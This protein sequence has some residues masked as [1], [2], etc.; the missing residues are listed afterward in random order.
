LYEAIK[1]SVKE[2][3]LKFLSSILDLSRNNNH[4]HKQTAFISLRIAE[5]MGLSPE[6]RD[7]LFIASLIHDSG[8]LWGEEEELAAILE[9]SNPTP[10]RHCLLAYLLLKNS[11][12]ITRLIPDV[13]RII[14][15]HHTKF[16]ELTKPEKCRLLLPIIEFT[17]EEVP[18]ESLIINI[19]SAISMMIDDQ[20][21]IL[22][23]AEEIKDRIKEL[24]DSLF[25]SDIVDAL[26]EAS[27]K[28]AFWLTLTSPFLE[29]EVEAIYPL[30]E[31]IMSKEEMVSLF[32]LICRFVDYK[33][34]LFATHSAGVSAMAE[35]LAELAQLSPDAVEK[36]KIAGYIHDL[37]KLSLPLSIVVKKDKLTKEEF[38]LVKVHPFTIYSLL[39][40]TK[41]LEG[42]RE[43]VGFHHERLDGSGYPFGLKG[44]AL[45][46]EARLL[47]VVDVFSALREKRPY[48]P[49]LEFDDA[50]K[51]LEEEAKEGKLD[52]EIVALLIKN[53]SDID[54]IF[55]NTH[56]F[57]NER[58]PQDK[59][60]YGFVL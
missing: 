10:W 28:E 2:I 43:L 53:L 44:E 9:P 17:R 12:L 6:R 26:L 1:V 21:P 34:A 29:E 59:F 18:L 60:Y 41:G 57:G 37:G 25:P 20:I 40:R 5:L 22:H 51:I 30:P 19:A 11:P 3:L 27:S 14:L 55:L 36:L 50:V 24:K 47:A 33:C 42:L 13:P 7:N 58:I 49:A 23:Q 52:G 8:L 45:P 15:Y 48:R 4:H 38:A 54:G 56:F 35:A 31:Y 39:S 32:Q 16:K 46:F